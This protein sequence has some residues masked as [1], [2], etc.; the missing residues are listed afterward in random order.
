MPHDH[1]HVLARVPRR[2]AGARP[3][4]D[5]RRRRGAPRVGRAGRGKTAPRCCCAPR[6]CSPRPGARRIN[7][8]TM[9]GQS[10]TAFQS[11][12][13]A[14]SRDDR[15]LALQRLLRAGAL[16][17]AADQQPRRVELRWSTAPLEGL[18]LRGV[19]VQLH[20]DRRQP[21]DRAGAD[22]QHRDLEAGGERDAERLL[23]L[24]ACSRPRA[25]RR[26]VINFLPGDARRDHQRAARLAGA[27]RHPLHRQHR[28]LQQH[29]EE[30]RREHRPLPHAIRGWS[31][32]PAARTSSSCTRRPIRRKSRSAMV[33]GGFEYQGQKCSAASRVYVPQSLWNEVRDRAVA[34]MKEIKVGDSR[35][36]R[37]FMGA[38]IDKKAFDQDQRATSTTRRRTRRSSRAAAAKGDEGLLHRADAGRRPRIRATGCCARR[39]SDRCVTAYVYPD[40]QV[41]A[42]RSRSS[43]RR[44]RTR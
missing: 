12:I 26:G 36:F 42:R 7:A 5:R 27:R 8:A 44:R 43:T 25:C 23:H 15:L 32:K 4:G 17:R 20:G 41:G 21:D 33:R 37:N 24:Q 13:D 29:V 16:Q 30:G 3:A 18:R 6:S 35:D 40:A 28:R 39:S 38:V 10:K 34:M 9:L 22:G 11:E 2:R 14:A 31:A 1:G 19:A